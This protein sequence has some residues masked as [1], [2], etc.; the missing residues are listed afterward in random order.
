MKYLINNYRLKNKY[1][2]LDNARIHH[3]KIVKQEINGTTNQ[4][5]FNVP[6]MPEFNPIEK[7]F[8]EMK[9]YVKSKNNNTNKN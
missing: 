2:L 9:K 6:Y 1:L 5:L 7:I 3:A 4:F 8:F